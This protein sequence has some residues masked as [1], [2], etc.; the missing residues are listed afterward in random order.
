MRTDLDTQPTVRR[1]LREDDV[2]AI[3]ALHRRVYGAEHG[4]NEAF[5]AGV[6]GSL[7][8]AAARGWPATGGGVWLVE[9]GGR[10]RGSLGLTGE[11][12]GLG[13][14]RWFV[15]EPTLRGRG[16]GTRLVAELVEL[17]RAQGMQELELETFSDLAVAARIYRANGFRVVSE[18]VRADWRSA[19]RPMTYQRYHRRLE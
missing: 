2:D 18:R 14:L 4:T 12:P 10:L 17:A 3:A 5:V 7:A 16:L 11:R 19:E 15:L 8:R 6:A 9:H 1:T 13:R